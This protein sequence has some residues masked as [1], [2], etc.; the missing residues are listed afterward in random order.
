MGRRQYAVPAAGALVALATGAAA[1][2][3]EPC[4]V[5]A[6][7][8]SSMCKST[9]SLCVY[10]YTMTET[11]MT[12]ILIIKSLVIVRTLF[13]DLLLFDYSYATY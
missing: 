8:I 4:A 3:N 7:L 5:A 10:V 9:N 13:P 12:I 6:Q 2:A 11:T 1:Q